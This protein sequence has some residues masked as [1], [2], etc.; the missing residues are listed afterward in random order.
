ME[1][2]RFMVSFVDK[3][4][5]VNRYDNRTVATMKTGFKIT[6]LESI[7]ERSGFATIPEFVVEILHKNGYHKDNKLN[8]WVTNCKGV[9][10]CNVDD[11]HD[12]VRGRRIAVS[13]AKR[14]AYAKAMNVVYDIVDKILVVF[15]ACENT[16]GE[17]CQFDNTEEVAIE[18]V[19]EY[20]VSNPPVQD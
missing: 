20:G 14:E 8:M 15:E 9:A 12:E 5:S 1:N 13:R 11:T 4:L 18:N 2:N 6:R 7:F 17:L 16:V 10:K 19:I 3:T